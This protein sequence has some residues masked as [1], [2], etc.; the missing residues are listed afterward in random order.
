[1]KRTPISDRTL[2]DYTRGEEIFN[3]VTHIVGGGLGVV[4]LALCVIFSALHHDPWAVVG[5]SVY[6]ASMIAL[7]T[8]SSVYHGL[9]PEHERAKKVMQIID[10]CTIYFLIAGTYTPIVLAGIRRIDPVAGWV[11]FGIVWGLAALATTLTAID[12]RKYRVFSMICYIGMGW[13]IICRLDLAMQALTKP[14]FFF[15][16]GGGVAYTIGAI[17]YGLGRSHRFMHSV[18]HI[19]VF[20][21]SLLQFFA[22]FF[23]LI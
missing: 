12:L 13:C 3:M 20:I 19:F 15:L 9:S 16:L 23:Y 1:M 4:V 6:G 17:L 21:G 2:P 11:L 7:Y 8:I 22:I 14:G 18:F 10:H 5:C